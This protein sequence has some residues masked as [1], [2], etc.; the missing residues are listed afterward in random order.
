VALREFLKHS[1]IPE[2]LSGRA[3]VQD[4]DELPQHPGDSGSGERGDCGKR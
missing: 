4:R 1:R 2:A 3:G